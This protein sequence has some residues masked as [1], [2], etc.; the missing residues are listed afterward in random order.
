[1]KEKFAYNTL[2]EKDKGVFWIDWDS[3]CDNFDHLDINWNP[4]LL[5]N[6][7]YFFDYWKASEM[8]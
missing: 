1:M 7:K 4:E 5:K 3:L 6:R 2:K 8:S